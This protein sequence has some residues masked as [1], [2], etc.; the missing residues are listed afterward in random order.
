[1]TRRAIKFWALSAPGE[2]G[3]RYARGA[4]VAFPARS[5][6]EDSAQVLQLTFN[7]SWLSDQGVLVS[8]SLSSSCSRA[9]YMSKLGKLK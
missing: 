7:S 3:V 1:M 9:S 2:T 8:L 5:C 6:F 4:A